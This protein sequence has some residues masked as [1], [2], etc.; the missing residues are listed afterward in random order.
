MPP[1]G[2]CCQG[3]GPAERGRAE[4]SVGSLASQFKKMGNKLD[5][6]EGG[7]GVTFTSLCVLGA[8]RIPKSCQEMRHLSSS[9]REEESFHSL[10]FADCL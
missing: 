5:G 1:Q 7:R 2:S 8:I 10:C 6:C 3:A 4:D 9:V